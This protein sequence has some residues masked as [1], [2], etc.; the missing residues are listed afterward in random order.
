MDDIA[1]RLDALQGSERDGLSARDG[2]KQLGLFADR[3]DDLRAV[4][5]FDFNSDL[6]GCL[7]GV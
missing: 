4:L 5:L 2:R 1:Q 6:H 7:S 3:V